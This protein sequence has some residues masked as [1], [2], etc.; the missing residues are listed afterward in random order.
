MPVEVKTITKGDG[1]NF[2]QK[3][4]KLAMHYVGTLKDGGKKF[5]SSRDRGQLF[6]FTIG[7]GQ[8]IKGWDEGVMK[9]SLG[10]RAILNI[11]SDYGYG[12]RGAGAAIPPNADL[13]FDVEL[14]KINGKKLIT[15]T[16]LKDFKER[17]DKW[18]ASKLEKYDSNE[19]FKAARDKK[20][21][22]RAAYETFLKTEVSKS[23]DEA[24]LLV[25][26]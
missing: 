2:P 17:L 4:D 9:M 16:E 1:K 20:Y 11:T 6:E 3:G 10:E 18:A 26:K 8:V 12:A 13:V 22:D 14:V 24:K 7:V 23:V 15:E 21:G 19:K 25:K 5:D